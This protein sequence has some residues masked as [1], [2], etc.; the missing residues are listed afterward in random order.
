[1]NK[2]GTPSTGY[3]LGSPGRAAGGERNTP[4]SINLNL[5]GRRLTSPL[6]GFGPLFEKRYRVRLV[7]VQSFRG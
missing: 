3:P 6:Q 7:G 2:S 1:M 5:D 4:G